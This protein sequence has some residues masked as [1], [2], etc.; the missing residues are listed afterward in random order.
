MMKAT[1]LAKSDYPPLFKNESG[2]R[3]VT[4]QRQVRARSIVIFKVRL[5]YPF[6]MSLIEYD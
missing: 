6:K 3:R 2:I 1:D 5:E 4:V